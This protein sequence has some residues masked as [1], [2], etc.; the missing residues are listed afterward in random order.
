M[1]LIQE[2]FRKD[3]SPLFD[4]FGPDRWNM[5]SGAVGDSRGRRSGGCA[6]YGQPCLS[7]GIGFRHKGGRLCG[8]FTAGGII[9]NIYFPT[10]DHR[11][12]VNA[13]RERFSSFVDEVI[14]VVEN[15]IES[16]QIAWMI[17]VELT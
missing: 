9:I 7:S 5:S 13:Y 14:K 3:E 11:Q 17:Y 1:C 15:T 12:T 2:H 10:R 16:R 6:I 4:F 8:F